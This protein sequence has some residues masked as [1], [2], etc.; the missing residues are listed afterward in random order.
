[1][2]KFII[3]LVAIFLRT[4]LCAQSALIEKIEYDIKLIDSDST[5]KIKAFDAN[6]IHGHIFDGGGVIKVHFDQ[7]GIKRIEE[8]IENIFCSDIGIT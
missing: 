2:K 4:I 1:M 3:L 8:E 6:Q 5:L 7:K